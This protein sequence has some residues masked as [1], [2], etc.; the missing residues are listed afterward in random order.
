MALIPKKAI[1]GF[2]I[3]SKK[4]YVELNKKKVPQINGKGSFQ[5]QSTASKNTEYLA[6]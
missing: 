3:N 2:T 6:N 5:C 1:A 4:R